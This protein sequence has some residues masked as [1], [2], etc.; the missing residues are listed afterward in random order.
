MLQPVVSGQRPLSP[1]VVHLALQYL[2]HAL[3]LKDSYKLLKPHVEGLLVQ[4]RGVG[5]V[6][7]FL[8]V[9]VPAVK[10]HQQQQQLMCG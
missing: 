1:R 4:V 9:G 8:F 10:Q 5:G 7:C 6:F 2:T 3:D